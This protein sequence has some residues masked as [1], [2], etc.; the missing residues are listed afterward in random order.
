[1]RVSF[2][3]SHFVQGKK[4]FPTNCTWRR[5]GMMY[6]LNMSLDI[7]G[8]KLEADRALPSTRFDA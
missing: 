4:Y 7:S 1:M 3:C 8:D 6:I 5:V 2:V